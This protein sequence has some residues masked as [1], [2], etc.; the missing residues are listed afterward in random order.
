M[1]HSVKRRA[2]SQQT[3]FNEK[4]LAILQICEKMNAERDL[5]PLLN[6]LV[7]EA[8]RLMDADRASIF[9]LDREKLELWLIVTLDGAQMRF[10]ARLGLAGAAAMTG[11]TINVEDAYQDSRFYKAI[12]GRTGYRT[13]SLLVV[14]LRNQEGEILGTFQVLNK[15]SGVFDEDD[16]KAL[17]ALATHVAM[18]I[19]TAQLVEELRR[20]REQL[21]EENTQLWKE[22]E[23]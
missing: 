17:Q 11:E 6:L 21:L 23:G 22:G 8:A 10:D 9:L 18:T 20:H 19:E 13:R 2:S 12:D 7:R 4:L 5:P 14:P 1:M 16:E 15:K 3:R